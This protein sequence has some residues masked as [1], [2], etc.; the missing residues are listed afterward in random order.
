MI[1]LSKITGGVIKEA[2]ELFTFRIAS[3]TSFVSKNV[4]TAQLQV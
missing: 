1:T 3:L 2:I 4:E